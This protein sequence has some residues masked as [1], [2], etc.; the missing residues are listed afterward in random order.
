MTDATHV[1]T[2]PDI[3]CDHCKNAIETELGDLD[4]V[5]QVTVDIAAKTVTVHGTAAEDTLVASI[6]KAGYQVA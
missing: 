2:V 5:D 3:S 6:G 1:F 4:D